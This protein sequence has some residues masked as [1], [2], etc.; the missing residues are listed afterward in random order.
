MHITCSTSLH[1]INARTNKIYLILMYG[2]QKHK[3]ITRASSH[4]YG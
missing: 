3:T 2:I 1:N 4:K